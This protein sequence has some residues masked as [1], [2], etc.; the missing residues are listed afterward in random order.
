MDNKAKEERNRYMR[1][2]RKRN[3]DKV[4]LYNQS[5]WEKKAA[6]VI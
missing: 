5:Y 6:Q 3:K 1:D 2:W 4:K